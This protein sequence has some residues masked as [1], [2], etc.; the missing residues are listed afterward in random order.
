MMRSWM[1]SL[2]RAKIKRRKSKG[3]RPWVVGCSRHE[4]AEGVM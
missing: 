3:F 4:D 2:R 1:M